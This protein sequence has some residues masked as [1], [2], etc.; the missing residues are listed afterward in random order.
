MADPQLTPGAKSVELVGNLHRHQ[1]RVLLATVQVWISKRAL[2]LT[3]RNRRLER[4]RVVALEELHGVQL[5]VV[6]ARDE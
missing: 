5:A 6:E 3:P 4:K 2:D 1:R